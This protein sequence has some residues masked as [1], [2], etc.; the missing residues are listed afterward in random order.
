V[1]DDLDS[2]HP[3]LCCVWGSLR[4]LM[5]LRASAIWCVALSALLFAVL[6]WLLSVGNSRRTKTTAIKEELNDNNII[7]IG[8]MY[9]RVCRQQLLGLGIG[10]K[11]NGVLGEAA[12][13]LH[14]Q[15]QK[16]Q[17]CSRSQSMPPMLGTAH[18][19]ERALLI[20]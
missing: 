8:M 17:L 1:Y 2:S 16:H 12:G 6:S 11:T 4:L 9:R 3:M 7:H 20:G 18:G 13:A 14:L 15:K 19:E 5:R 10:R